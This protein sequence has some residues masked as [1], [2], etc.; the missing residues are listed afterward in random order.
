MVSALFSGVQVVQG[1][2]ALTLY[3]WGT[4]TARH[5]FCR[6]CGIYTHHQRRSDLTQYGVN[7]AI[8]DGMNPRDLGD[9]PWVDG[10][11]HPAD[12]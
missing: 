5:W 6:V 1:A 9:V 10:V 3:Q 2:G 7:V 11:N 8:L 12:G 4:G